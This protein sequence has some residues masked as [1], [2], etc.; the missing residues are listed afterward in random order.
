MSGRSDLAAV[1][2]AAGFSRRMGVFKPLLPFGPATVIERVIATVRESGVETIRVVVGWGADRLIPVLEGC[3]VSWVRTERFGEGMYASVRAGV[4]ILPSD[5]VAFF[6]LPG[7]MPLVR[8]ATLIHL[9]SEWDARPGGILYPR[10]ASA[11]GHPPLIGRA[12]ISAI[13]AETPL[14]GLREL[15]RR[16]DANAREVEVADPGVLI[17]LDTPADYQRLLRE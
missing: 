6:V 2:P 14:G 16:H 15:L 1:I 13:L 3:S 4:R 17:D 11:R 10:Y 9:V 7:D 8:P 5:A 12:Y